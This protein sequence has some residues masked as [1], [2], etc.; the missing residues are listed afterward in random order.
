MPTTHLF[1]AAD[2][3]CIGSIAFIGKECISI[4]YGWEARPS[5]R[6]VPNHIIG[7]SLAW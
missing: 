2:Y 5:E 7:F 1:L 4:L 3:T 6:I